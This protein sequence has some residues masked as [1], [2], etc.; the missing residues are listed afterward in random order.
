MTYTDEL[1]GNAPPTSLDSVRA[2]LIRLRRNYQADDEE[3]QSR[4]FNANQLDAARVHL[5]DALIAWIDPAI[6]AE[7]A[8]W[9]A[10]LRLDARLDAADRI[11]QQA[12][13]RA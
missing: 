3:R 10:Q 4:G 1:L 6:A 13:E 8:A 11:D 5:L 7:R 2:G 12:K 9:D